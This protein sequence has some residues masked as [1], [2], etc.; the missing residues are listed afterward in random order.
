MCL[1]IEASSSQRSLP[2]NDFR[3]VDD[4]NLESLCTIRY[5]QNAFR[6]SLYIRYIQNAFRQ[7]LYIRYIQNAVNFKDAPIFE[8]I[9][10]SIARKF[11]TF[12][13]K[14]ARLHF[15]VCYCKKYR[16]IKWAIHFRN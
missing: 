4:E 13:K 12:E 7:S 16:E 10:D 14:T 5:I 15:V 3:T 9:V 6:Q 2:R 11:S 8:P 1:K